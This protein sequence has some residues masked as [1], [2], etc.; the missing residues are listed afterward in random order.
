MA[1]GKPERKEASCSPRLPLSMI[2][3]RAQPT[4]TPT[5]PTTPSSQP[6]HVPV[7]VAPY[8]TH[9]IAH[10]GQLTLVPP[11]NAGHIRK[12]PAG[13]KKKRA[14]RTKGEREREGARERER[15]RD[16]EPRFTTAVPPSSSR[17]LQPARSRK[18]LQTASQPPREH[19]PLL[20]GECAI[21]HAPTL[22]DGRVECS[23][24]RSLITPH[25]HSSRPS[26]PPR[27]TRWP[28]PVPLN[29]SLSIPLFPLIR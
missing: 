13:G 9:M 24:H 2:S 21:P 19:H 27:R 15:E 10:H 3:S 8:L 11:Q 4:H 14:E 26:P 6:S 16:E 23:I 7:T 12:A 28:R 5:T 25:P 29:H 17:K 1:C 20:D 18:L 22:A